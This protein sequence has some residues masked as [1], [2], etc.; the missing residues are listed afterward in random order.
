MSRKHIINWVT[1][2]SVATTAGVILACAATVGRGVDV[3]RS[4]ERMDKIDAHLTATDT[5]VSTLESHNATNDLTIFY[6]LKD[7]QK[8]IKEVNHNITN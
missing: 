6:L 8:S 5:R 3:V 4:P 1:W 7:I 2:S